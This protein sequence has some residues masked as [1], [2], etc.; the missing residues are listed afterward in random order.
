[1]I[2]AL[3]LAIG[4]A[5]ADPMESV[6]RVVQGSSSCAGTLV[7]DAGTVLTAWH[8]VTQ[9]GRPWVELR[10]GTAGP[11]RIL[12]VDRASDLALLEAPALAG[13]AWLPVADAAPEIGARVAVLG[14]P[15]G[16]R[17]P[18]GFLLGTLR[19]SRAEGVVSA[20][21][22]FAVQLG[23]PVNP[24]NSGGPVV[25]EDGTLVGVVSRK[26]RGEGVAFATRPEA[27]RALLERG[28]RPLG[29]FGGTLEAHIIA[30]MWQGTHGTTALGGR[31]TLALRD[32]VVVTAAATQALSSRWDAVRYGAVRWMLAEGAVGVRQRF[33]RGPWALRVDVYGGVGA[34]AEIAADELDLSRRTLP[35]PMVGGSLRLGLLILDG[36]AVHADG[37]WAFRGEIGLRWPGRLALF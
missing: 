21:G 17:L 18:G 3:L 13:H 9:G 24:G 7:D 22:P 5:S 36:A 33:F 23:V 16:T 2:G 32:R 15:F 12:G 27:I 34:L 19:W 26:L 14:H 37:A 8:C 28:G 35:A 30:T 10:D 29:P 4:L 20:V 25:D 11:A 31:V 1:M 6:V